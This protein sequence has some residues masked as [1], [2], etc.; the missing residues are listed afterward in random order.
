MKSVQIKL[1]LAEH[2]KSFVQKVAVFNILKFKWS[3][4]TSLTNTIHIKQACNEYM[5]SGK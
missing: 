5:S 2:V 1:K 3:L 4:S